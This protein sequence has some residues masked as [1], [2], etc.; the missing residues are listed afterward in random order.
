[1]GFKKLNL[2]AAAVTAV[3]A[4]SLG[5]ATVVLAAA[6]INITGVSQLDSS[7]S[8]YSVDGSY[9]NT[10]PAVDLHAVIHNETQNLT[11]NATLHNYV[12]TYSGACLLCGTLPGGSQPGDII[13]VTLSWKTD[14]LQV[15]AQSSVTFV[16]DT[17]QIISINNGG[18]GGG[19]CSDGRVNENCAAP[20]IVYCS[21]DTVAFWKMG[22]DK[23]GNPAGYLAY[24]VPRSSLMKSVSVKTLI[25]Q[26]GQDK[27]YLLPDGRALLIAR[28]GDG[29]DYFMYFDPAECAVLQ[30]GA[31]WGVK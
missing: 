26:S 22:V 11:G 17:G 7:C 15:L 23:N 1:M 13:K 8:W 19:T 25:K 24:S 16:C 3:L 27:L 5:M 2:K 14:A 9:S 20:T 30:E 28:Q 10:D 4:L 31:E 21:E 12:N 6:S 29:K 18:G